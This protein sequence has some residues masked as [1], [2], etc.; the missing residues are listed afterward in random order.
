MSVLMCFSYDLKIFLFNYSLIL[1]YL[2]VL[3]K[4]M[5]IQN[6]QHRRFFFPH[7][8]SRSIL[9]QQLHHMIELLV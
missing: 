1:S 7:F 9:K 5:I 6:K 4:I 2:N 3:M 8:E